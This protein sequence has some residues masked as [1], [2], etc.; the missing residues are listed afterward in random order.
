MPV[1]LFEKFTR[2]ALLATKQIHLPIPKTAIPLSH[3]VKELDPDEL[4]VK[5]A[6][7]RRRGKTQADHKRFGGP[8]IKPRF[9]D[10][11]RLGSV[12]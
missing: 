9:S 7:R 11:K 12:L 10:A 4:R 5:Y 3:G 6:N 1:K 8:K 2:H